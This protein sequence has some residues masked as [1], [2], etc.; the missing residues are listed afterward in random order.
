MNNNG[1]I[2]VSD[3][4][5]REDLYPRIKHDPAL[6]QKYSQNIEVLPAIEVNQ[7]NELIDG[8]HRW[9]AHKTV[10]AKSIPVTIT[11]TKSDVELLALACLRNAA[12]GLQLSDKDKSKMAIRLYAAGTGLNKEKIAEALSV[13]HRSVTGYLTD[14]DEQLRKERKEKIQAMWLRCYSQEEIAKVVGVDVA[15]VS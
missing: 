6:V 15:T 5:Y 11:V 10:E 2:K 1:Y 13:T 4:I 3:I 7:N 8:W 14:I 9:T 12:H